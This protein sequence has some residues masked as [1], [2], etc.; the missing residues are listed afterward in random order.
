MLVFSFVVGSD[1]KNL[2]V[3]FW[4]NA[5]MHGRQGKARQAS[6][7]NVR[8]GGRQAHDEYGRIC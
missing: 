1:T 4:E 8:Q 3:P 5:C 2:F 7:L 6:K